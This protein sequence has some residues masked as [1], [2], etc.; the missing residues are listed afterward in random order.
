MFNGAVSGLDV[1][2]KTRLSSLH[3][4]RLHSALRVPKMSAVVT[5][6]AAADQRPGGSPIIGNVRHRQW[7]LAPR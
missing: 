1:E 3:R 7:S 6:V 2:L 4:N 5:R